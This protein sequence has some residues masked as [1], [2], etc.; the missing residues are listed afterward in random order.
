M[1]MFLKIDNESYEVEI[2]D[3]NVR[4]ILATVNGATFEVTLEEAE[5]SASN[6]PVTQTVAAPVMVS[7]KTT[8]PAPSAG[9]KSVVAPI[10]GVI[11]AIKVR[12]GDT[13]TSAQELI[14]LEAMKM[15]NSIRATRPG[16]IA[17]IFVAVGDQV[18]YNHVLLEFAD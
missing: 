12:E 6:L 4:P 17:R 3:L 9:G 10:P 14:V 18:P 7:P 2:A 15:K 1:K 16:K 13:V 11:D 8:A 5:A